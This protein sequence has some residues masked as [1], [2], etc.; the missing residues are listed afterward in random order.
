[1]K[2]HTTHTSEFL[3]L[4]PSS[5]AWPTANY[6]EDII[7]GLVDTGIWP[8]S[9]SFSDEGMT[10]VP[11]R[12]KGKC[13]P[14]TQFNSSTC[15]K[16]LIGARY[17]NKGLLAN[18][19]EVKIPMN[20]TRDTDGHGTHTAST[21]AGNYVNGASYFG[22]ANGTSSGMAPRARIAMYKA[23]WRYGVYE[24]DVLAAIDQAIQDGVDILSVFNCSH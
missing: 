22:Y 9:E 17:Y 5:G 20:S 7:I 13:E 23:I 2:V 14:G 4:S 3:G 19:P 16:K 6:G 10:E 21:A 24:S 12:W 8:E 11:S 18:E 15:N 1:M